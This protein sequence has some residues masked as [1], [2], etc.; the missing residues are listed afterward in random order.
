M[1]RINSEMILF[2]QIVRFDLTAFPRVKAWLEKLKET[3]VF[4]RIDKTGNA[5]LKELFPYLARD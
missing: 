5:A 1:F 2:F 3:E 4:R